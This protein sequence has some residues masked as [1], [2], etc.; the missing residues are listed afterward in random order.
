MS[1]QVLFGDRADN[2]LDLLA[3]AGGCFPPRRNGNHFE[4][5][6]T[7]HAH[8]DQEN[9]SNSSILAGSAKKRVQKAMSIV[10]SSEECGYT[11][12]VQAFLRRETKTG[13]GGLLSCVTCG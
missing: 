5:D 11:R 12:A 4:I 6:R 3:Q 9:P 2:S 10:A 8:M 1:K 7:T 13:V